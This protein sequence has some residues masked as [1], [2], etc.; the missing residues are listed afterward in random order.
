MSYLV[1]FILLICSKL[2]TKLW[3][4]VIEV[5]D[6]G[7]FAFSYIS[8][9]RLGIRGI[10]LFEIIDCLFFIVT[11]PRIHHPV[12]QGSPYDPRTQGQGHYIRRYP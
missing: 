6:R 10:D 11:S 7:Y 3:Y 2:S 9:Y 1:C 4:L 12:W 5:G 8:V